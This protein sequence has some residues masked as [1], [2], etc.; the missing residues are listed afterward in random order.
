MRYAAAAYAIF[1]YTVAS[2]VHSDESCQTPNTVAANVLLQRSFTTKSGRT[3]T[4]VTTIQD[5]ELESPDLGNLSALLSVSALLNISALDK[6]DQKSKLHH[7]SHS[8]KPDAEGDICSHTASSAVALPKKHKCA[9]ECPFSQQLP[10]DRCHKVCVGKGTCGKFHPGRGFA[11]PE[12]KQCIPACGRKRK[13]KVSGCR[14]CAGVGLCAECMTGFALVDDGARCQNVMEGVW[15][16][17]YILLGSVFVILVY[18]TVNLTR[19]PQ[20]NS[21]VCEKSL[22][23][24]DHCRCWCLAEDKSWHQYPLMATDVKKENI[25]GQGVILYFRRLSFCH[26]LRSV[27]FCDFWCNVWSVVVEDVSRRGRRGFQRLQ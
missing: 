25:S 5:N 21:D 15:P 11:D 16:I 1:P 18:Y 3:Q 24:R 2:I 12:S 14:R 8:D 22:L 20:I 17:I 9:P 6:P 19:R 26:G 7:P 4:F 13:D 27:A 23:F 10:G